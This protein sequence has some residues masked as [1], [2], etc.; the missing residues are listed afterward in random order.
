MTPEGLVML[1]LLLCALGCANVIMLMRLWLTGERRRQ[2]AEA[3]L[4]T[5]SALYRRLSSK[6][7]HDNENQGKSNGKPGDSK[8]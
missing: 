2:A 7:R 6:R 8:S 4:A 5:L 1:M 3:K